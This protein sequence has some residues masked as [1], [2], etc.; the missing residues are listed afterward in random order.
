MSIRLHLIWGPTSTGKTAK[1]IALARAIGAP[2]IALDRVQ[3]YPELATGSGRPSLSELNG[4][5]R[6]YICERN[7]S[8]GIVSS[9]EANNLLKNKVEQYSRRYPQI[10][11]E[12]GSVS[13]INEM[14]SD[15]YWSRGFNWVLKKI[16]LGHHED[17]MVR[18][19]KR[20]WEMIRRERGGVSILDELVGLWK[21]PTNH[22]TLEDTDG[23]RAIIRFARAMNMHVHMMASLDQDVMGTLVERVADEYWQHAIWQEKK[24]F[25]IPATWERADASTLRGIYANGDET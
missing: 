22:F 23:Y 14:I 4:T 12:G 9:V 1:S 20:V 25:T 3:C 17:F 6:V 21:D 5:I 19:R 8:S 24:F 2:V 15:K 16:D 13:L 18:A 10:I 11:L 7:V